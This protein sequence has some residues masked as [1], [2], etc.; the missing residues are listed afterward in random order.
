MQHHHTF[1]VTH[2]VSWLGMIAC[3]GLSSWNHTTFFVFTFRKRS[4]HYENRLLHGPLTRYVKL[5]LR[6]RR[7]C[8]EHF[9]PPTS[10]DACRDR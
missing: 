3:D 6:I 10:K 5:W 7:E 2:L 8:R 9:P 4:D 1:R